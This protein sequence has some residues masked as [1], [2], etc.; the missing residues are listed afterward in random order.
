ML[1]ID[2]EGKFR[3]L[4]LKTLLLGVATGGRLEISDN[5]GREADDEDRNL[6]GNCHYHLRDEALLR[7]HHNLLKELEI[8]HTPIVISSGSPSQ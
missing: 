7:Q 3:S 5:L 6:R 1:S 2:V 4:S 8:T